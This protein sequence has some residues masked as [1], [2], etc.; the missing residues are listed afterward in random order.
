MKNEKPVADPAGCALVR[1]QLSAT[2]DGA[3]RPA[4]DS[5]RLHLAACSPCSAFAAD[6]G[7]LSALFA[8]LR[9]AEPRPEL[10]R[11]LAARAALAAAQTA[12]APRVRTWALRAAAGAIGFLSVYALARGGG[13]QPGASELH[14]LELLAGTS[15]VFEEFAREIEASP[16]RA[17]LTHLGAS[18]EASR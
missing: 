6:L 17:L 1:E 7:R 11:A 10:G 9:S 13:E 16:E 8:P 14:S 18:L 12:P 5:L 4:D 2:H 15:L 3:P